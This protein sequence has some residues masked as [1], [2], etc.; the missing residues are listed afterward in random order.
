MV[1][2]VNFIKFSKVKECKPKFCEKHI[3]LPKKTTGDFVG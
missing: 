1:K 3:L 2:C